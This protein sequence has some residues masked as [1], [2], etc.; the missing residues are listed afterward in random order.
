MPISCFNG[1]LHLLHG[2]AHAAFDAVIDTGRIA[3]DQRWTRISLSLGD[4][5]DGLVHIGAQKMCIRDRLYA[6]QSGQ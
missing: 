3:D 1:F 6:H 4:G 2:S 5:F